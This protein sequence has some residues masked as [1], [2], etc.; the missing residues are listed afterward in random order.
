[1]SKKEEKLGRAVEEFCVVSK[2]V[3]VKRME[4]L[5]EKYK[6]VFDEYN[7]WY[8][9][10]NSPVNLVSEEDLITKEKSE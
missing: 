8:S 3:A 9:I 10:I 6:E 2:D 4:L 7:M 5:L 1:M